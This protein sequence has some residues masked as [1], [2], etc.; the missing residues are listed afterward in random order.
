MKSRE[1][2]TCS[3]LI[4]RVVAVMVA[5]VILDSLITN[6]RTLDVRAIEIILQYG[7]HLQD[8]MLS[9]T[10]SE[11]NRADEVMDTGV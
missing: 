4:A 11:T 3:F 6:A 9:T 10:I 7:F 1:Y 8:H 2:P 5:T